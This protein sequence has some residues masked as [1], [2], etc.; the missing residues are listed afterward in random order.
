MIKEIINND[1]ILYND[2]CINVLKDM[3]ND[4]IDLIVT[5]CSY[6]IISGGIA[7]EERKDETSGISQ[8]IAKSDGTNC[9]NKWLKK[10]ENTSE[11][12]ILNNDIEFDIEI[13]RL[14]E[15]C[16][17]TEESL[18]NIN[19]MFDNMIKSNSQIIHTLVN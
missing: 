5:D 7:I 3:D 2:D 12:F 4:T 6:K 18:I 11:T 13:K 17:K 9:S 10:D 8:R 1:I 14:L 19:N 16:K 15:I